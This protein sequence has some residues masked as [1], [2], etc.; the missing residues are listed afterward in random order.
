M[1][2]DLV[3]ESGAAMVAQVLEATDGRGADVVIE[4]TGVM[5]CI[6]D[7]IRMVRFWGRVV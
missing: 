6:A 5:S 3:I 1:G 7:A 2:A 4:C